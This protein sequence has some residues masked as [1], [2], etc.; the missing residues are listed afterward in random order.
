MS[1]EIIDIYIDWLREILYAVQSKSEHACH[2]RWKLEKIFLASL[3][4]ARAQK[5][6]WWVCSTC[7]WSSQVLFWA[8]PQDLRVQVDSQKSKSKLCLEVPGGL[9]RVTK[10]LR[11]PPC[12]A[13]LVL[14]I[15]LVGCQISKAQTKSWFLSVSERDCSQI[16][17]GAPSFKHEKVMS[18]WILVT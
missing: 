2:P 18:I 5:K 13:G 8:E 6:I 1:D 9:C 4:V 17:R 15:I 7:G 3:L 16:S 11:R 12:P 14:V 10:R